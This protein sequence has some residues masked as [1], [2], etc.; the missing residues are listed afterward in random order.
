MYKNVVGIE[1]MACGMCEAHIAEAIRG[2]FP[3]AKKVKAS[4]RKKNAVFLTEGPVE[5]T[6]VRDVIDVAGYHFVDFA[7]TE[8]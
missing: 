6:A 3:D 4:R 7:S 8:K 1:G 5:E 2:A